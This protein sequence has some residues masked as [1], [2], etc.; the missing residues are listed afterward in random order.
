MS[1]AVNVTMQIIANMQ[2]KISWQEIS[3]FQYELISE[4]VLG[5]HKNDVGI[6]LVHWDWLYHYRQL[7]R[8][9]KA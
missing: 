9:V 4:H 3:K 5:G 7:S 1:Y 8:A 2:Y 6:C